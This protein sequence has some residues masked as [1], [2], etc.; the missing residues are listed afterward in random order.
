MVI[1]SIFGGL[2]GDFDDLAFNQDNRLVIVPTLGDKA[3]LAVPDYNG[4]GPQG[5]A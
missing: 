3:N 1:G 2:I 4:D 5:L